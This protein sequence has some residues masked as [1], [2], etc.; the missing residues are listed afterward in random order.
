MGFKLRAGDG[1]ELLVPDG[2]YYFNTKAR[3]RRMMLNS[4]SSDARRVYAC[5]ELATMGFQ[6]ELAVTM[7]RGEQR[8]LTPTDIGQQTGLSRQNVRRGFEELEDAGLA[9]RQALDGGA[10]R[11]GHVLLYSWAVPRQPKKEDC[12]RARLQLPDWF[13]ESWEPLKSLISRYKYSVTVDEVAAGDYKD[14]IDAA[15]RAYKEAEMVAV[16]ALEKVCAR[17]QS[18]RASSYRKNGKNIERT[19]AAVLPGATPPPPSPN[20]LPAPIEALVARELSIDDDAAQKL[21][22]GC[23]A[24]EPSV[25]GPEIVALANTKIAA[26][27]EQVRTGKIPSPVGLLI[28]HVPR[29]CRGGTLQVVR[30][31]IE[32]E[33][34]ERVSRIAYAREAWPE[35]NEEERAE[36]LQKYPELAE[37]ALGAHT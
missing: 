6:Q 17:A 12:S 13:P 11:K 31:Q 30:D 10:L 4:L 28:K 33:K 19:A 34:Q 24:V 22:A 5:L 29:M 1:T 26:I 36:V 9:L 15:A 37:L 27:R 16:R 18:P 25:T 35:L 23:K 3:G 21:V 8:P 2:E 7:E 20:L 32:A 14:E